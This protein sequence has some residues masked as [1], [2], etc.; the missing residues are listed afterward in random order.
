[1]SVVDEIDF[2]SLSYAELQALE[3]KVQKE[4]PRAKE[5]SRK[6]FLDEMKRV[7]KD[8]DMS[9]E[10]LLEVAGGKASGGAHRGGKK[11]GKLPP[12]Y[13]NPDDP[14]LTWSGHGKQP[15]WFVANIEAG[16]SKDDMLIKKS[17]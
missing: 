15:A 13:K 1:V 16:K 4:L 6:A 11:P 17:A 7:A 10:E 2:S 14:S 3:E 12:K 5:R 9:L 8:H